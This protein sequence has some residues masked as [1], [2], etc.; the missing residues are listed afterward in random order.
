MT[1]HLSME[2]FPGLAANQCRTST[3]VLPREAPYTQGFPLKG[4]P[5]ATSSGTWPTRRPGIEAGRAD[6]SEHGFPARRDNWRRRPGQHRPGRLPAVRRRNRQN[7]RKDSRRRTRRIWTDHKW[8]NV[9]PIRFVCPL[10]ATESRACRSLGR[11][12][13]E[14]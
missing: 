4:Y 2:E 12:H 10:S 13:E 8:T 6:C 9:V 3:P 5:V 1:T 7:G 14:S 11:S